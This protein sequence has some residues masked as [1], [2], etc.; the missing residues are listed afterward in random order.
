MS[1]AAPNGRTWP[2]SVGEVLGPAA[3]GARRGARSPRT[4]GRPHGRGSSAARRCGPAGRDCR[5]AVIGGVRDVG[6]QAVGG[7]H[8]PR[9][10]VGRALSY[11]TWC[12]AVEGNANVLRAAAR[13]DGR[14]VG[15]AGAR[16]FRFMFKLPRTITHERRLRDADDEL[17][18]FLDAARP[19]GG[20]VGTISVQ[21]P[22]VVRAARPRRAG[23]V[24]APRLPAPRTASPSR[25]GTPRSSTARRRPGARR[26]PRGAGV[27]WI[28]LDT[29]T[30]F[31]AP[32]TSD[33]ERDAWAEQAP[34]AP[35]DR[36]RHRPAD[37]ALP[38]HGDDPD[39]TVAGRQPVAP[40]RG[41]VPLDEGRTPDGV[42]A[43]ARQRGRACARPPVPRRGAGDSAPALDPPPRRGRPAH[44]PSSERPAA[45]CP[46][47]RRSVG[48]YP[49]PRRPSARF[50]PA[51]N[52][53]GPDTPT[54]DASVVRRRRGV[55]WPGPA[56]RRRGH[57]GVVGGQLRGPR[58]RCDRNR[59]ERGGSRDS[60]PEPRGQRSSASTSGGM[61]STSPA[62]TR[63]SGDIRVLAA[64]AASSSRECT[65]VPTA[66]SVAST[67]PV[68]SDRLG[69][70]ARREHE[71]RGRP[72]RRRC[73]AGPG[74]LRREVQHPHR[75]HVDGDRAP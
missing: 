41:R 46:V 22:G 1:G 45:G 31:A 43:H 72:A 30:M 12:N 65:T 17:G 75:E 5:R 51:R 32:P 64:S 35:S 28:G 7:R 34:P 29:T 59:A 73:A 39:A 44:P 9:P 56:R 40:G 57:G 2:R 69:R 8:V 3:G 11:A 66:V 67:R 74:A 19:A 21:L 27:E 48:S 26:R 68:T 58:F 37:R 36:G 16:D 23:R 38:G 55:R 71:R 33:G 60:P 70:P 54:I 4:R 61:G 24:R 10:G 20:R 63:A 13:D 15:R 52:R 50:R 49:R 6:A 62:A 14:R 42:R 47:H 53:S 18:P 25:C